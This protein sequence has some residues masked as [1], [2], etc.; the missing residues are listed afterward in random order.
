MKLAALDR[1]LENLAR[2]SLSQ[3]SGKKVEV[4]DVTTGTKTVYH[5]IRAA[6]RALSIDKRYIEN[7]IYLNQEKPVFGKY[8]FKFI[9]EIY[10]NLNVSIQ[11]SSKSLEV[12]DV[13]TN[14]TTIYPSVSLAARTLGIRQA[15]ISLYLK[16]A[17]TKPF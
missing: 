16:D 2:L 1:S 12:T 17:R 15:S 11:K 5:A 10:N 4:T 13:E 7:Y 14:V 8:I 3:T 9:G 6:S